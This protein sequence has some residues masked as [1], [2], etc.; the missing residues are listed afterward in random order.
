MKNHIFLITISPIQ[1]FITQSR[2][3]QDLYASSRILSEMIRAGIEKFE[4][5]FGDNLIIFPNFER[6]EPEVSLPN[7]FIGKIKNH[8]FNDE[9]LAKKAN[10][11]KSAITDKFKAFAEKALKKVD[12]EPKGFHEQI[13]DKFDVFWAYEEVKTSYSDAYKKLELQIGAVKN[14]RAFKQFN[15]DK[16]LEY[17]EQGRKCSIDGEYNALFYNKEGAGNT[18]KH[19]INAIP[20]LKDEVWLGEKEGLSAVSFTKRFTEFNDENNKR[21]KFSSTAKVALMQEINALKESK[22]IDAQTIYLSYKNYFKEADFDEQLFYEDNLTSHYFIKHGLKRYLKRLPNIR[23]NH[24]KLKPYL[25]TKY[26]ALILFDGDKMGEWV[27]GKYCKP[28]IDLEDFHRKFSKLLSDY[29]KYVRTEVLNPELYNGQAVY[30]GGDD[31]MGFVNIDCLFDVMQKLRTKF[32]IQINKS[33]VLKQFKKEGVDFT[34]SAGIVIAHYKAPLSE[35]LKKARKV[36]KTAKDEADRNAFSIAVMKSSGEVQQASFKWLIN[37]DNWKALEVIVKQMNKTKQGESNFSNTFITN[38]T[39]ELYGLAGLQ[40][41][42][43]ISLK[44]NKKAKEALDKGVL[45]EIERLVKR[46]KNDKTATDN[47]VAIMQE[48][49]T[50][51]WQNSQFNDNI[52]HLENFIH[53][54]HI[55]DFLTQ[56]IK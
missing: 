16:K 45:K 5:L 54:L 53:A 41:Q 12:G 36:E 42:G 39:K 19:N 2:K 55:A 14:I 25:K 8:D 11:V 1:S 20:I 44:D 26:Y 35:V 52:K 13:Q 24:K 50:T 31:F 48:A 49:V 46:A 43:F 9:Q 23:E 10:E 30:A 21:Y 51:L 29:G 6:N 27:S 37:L 40:L 18:F 34:F 22:D 15:Y 4:R 28:N 38:L 47:D 7:R 3:T 56:K 33:E 17:G 32:D